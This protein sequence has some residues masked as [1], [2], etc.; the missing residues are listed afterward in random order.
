MAG[1]IFCQKNHS[2]ATLRRRGGPAKPGQKAF[3]AAAEKTEQ[4]ELK[5][6][7][8]EA[9][10]K[11]AAE[12][13]AQQLAEPMQ[14]SVFFLAA[15]TPYPATGFVFETPYKGQREIWGV[16]SRHVLLEDAKT[17][18]AAFVVNGKTHI[19]VADVV[20]KGHAFHLDATLLRFRNVPALL[21]LVKPL[22]FSDRKNSLHQITSSFGFSSGYMD[23][24]AQ[25]NR[26]VI[27][28]TPNRLTTVT[29]PAAFSRSGTC[30]GPLV[31]PHGEVVGLHC[32][33]S[34]VSDILTPAFLPL[35]GQ[36]L[37]P[38]HA[39]AQR[40]SYAVPARRILDM[41]RAVHHQF[42]PEGIYWHNAFIDRLQINEYILQVRTYQDNHA[43]RTYTATQDEPFLDERFLEKFIDVSG[44]NQM[45]ITLSDG[46]HI[47]QLWVDLN[48]RRVTKVQFLHKKTN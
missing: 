9:A 35:E 25:T 19:F 28:Q 45:R 18:D 21:R 44:A 24:F 5:N 31:D 10:Q 26:Q 6:L 3:Q 4:T 2:P 1:K 20:L 29:A 38:V 30:G 12:Q 22:R 46:L 42:E 40:V 8:T 47:R 43:Q 32:G 7:V 34:P 14:R 48:T 11:H 41:V 13:L 33:T 39:K 15:G 17:L 37:F 23:L 16:T 36:T 27:Y